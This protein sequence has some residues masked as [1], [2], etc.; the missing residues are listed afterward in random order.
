[1][2]AKLLGR[3]IKE[4]REKFGMSQE[5]LGEI[6]GCPQETINGIESGKLDA[7]VS[8]LHKVVVH[9][10]SSANRLLGLPLDKVREEE[11]KDKEEGVCYT[12]YTF[13][14]FNKTYFPEEY[15]ERSIIKN[16]IKDLPIVSYITVHYGS[17]PRYGGTTVEFRKIYTVHIRYNNHDEEIKLI[18]KLTDAEKEINDD[19]EIEV[20]LK[21]NSTPDQREVI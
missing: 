12:C 18:M 10:G 16:A 15:R 14:E 11:K 5:R 3:K 20:E 21:Y 8:L 6:C 2:F 4:L 17:A 19:S 7:T 9:F 1:M 13:D